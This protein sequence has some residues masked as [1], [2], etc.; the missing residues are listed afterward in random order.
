MAKEQPITVLVLPMVPAHAP[1]IGREGRVT[2]K[3]EAVAIVYEGPAI[4][5]YQAWLHLLLMKLDA[6]FPVL[7]ESR[8]SSRDAQLY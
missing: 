6:L 8:E 4:A 1:A 5:A 2:I 3:E 7:A